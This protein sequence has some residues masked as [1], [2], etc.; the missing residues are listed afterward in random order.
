MLIQVYNNVYMKYMKS[1]HE[2]HKQT[3]Y[4]IT[5]EQCRKVT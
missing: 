3:Q 1:I 4:R 2:L 5:Y